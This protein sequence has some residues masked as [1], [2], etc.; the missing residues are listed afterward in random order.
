LEAYLKWAV[1]DY[2]VLRPHYKHSPQTPHEVYFGKALAF[3]V[4]ERIK[5]AG[6]IRVQKNKEMPCNTC[7]GNA[8]LLMQKKK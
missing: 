6:K 7:A 4:K 1:Y 3:D 5:R 2:N 8:F